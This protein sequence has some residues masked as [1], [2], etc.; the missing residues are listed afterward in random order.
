MDPN[1]VSLIYDFCAFT[2]LAFNLR[3]VTLVYQR[4]ITKWEPNKQAAL[5]F[6]IFLLSCS[7]QLHLVDLVAIAVLIATPTLR[8]I[9]GTLLDRLESP[10]D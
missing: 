5:H 8:V 9:S 3:F 10:K 2:Q 7:V 1:R 4:Q 6:F